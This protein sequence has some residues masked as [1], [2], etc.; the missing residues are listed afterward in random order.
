MASSS[1]PS[2]HEIQQRIRLACGRGPVRLWRNNTGALV[3]QQGRCV[4]FGLCKGSSDL[5]GLRSVVVTPEMAGLPAAGAAA[6]WSGSCLPLHS[7]GPDRP[8]AGHHR[9]R[10]QRC[11]AGRWS[12][13][14]PSGRLSGCADGCTAWELPLRN[15]RVVAGIRRSR[16]STVSRDMGWLCIEVEVPGGV[17][18]PTL[19]TSPPFVS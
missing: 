1:S 6:R 3:D 4:R 17:D 11:A 14:R 7:A 8:R 10:E 12:V 16:L 18:T 5:I 15:R 13:C 19:G 2:E 9:T